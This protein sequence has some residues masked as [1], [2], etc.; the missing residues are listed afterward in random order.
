MPSEVDARRPDPPAR[1]G[2]RSGGV[3]T[4]ALL[5]SFL[6]QNTFIERQFLSLTIIFFPNGRQVCKEKV[7]K[8]FDSFPVFT[9]F[10]DNER[11]FSF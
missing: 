7:G 9:N 4:R 1:W 8:T 11:S 2:I 10:Q 5:L 6:S 3:L